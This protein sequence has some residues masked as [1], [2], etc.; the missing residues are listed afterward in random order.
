MLV[1]GIGYVV[2]NK[3]VLLLLVLYLYKYISTLSYFYASI[4]RVCPEK[5]CACVRPGF[6]LLLLLAKERR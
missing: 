6:A 3:F 5:L 4:L 1:E 2:Y